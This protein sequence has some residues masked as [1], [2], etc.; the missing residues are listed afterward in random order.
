MKSNTIIIWTVLS[1]YSHNVNEEG[2]ERERE[3]CT[4]KSKVKLQISKNGEQ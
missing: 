4:L 3:R 1:C 2:G